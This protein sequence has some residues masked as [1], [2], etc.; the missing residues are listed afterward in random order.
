MR[1]PC[2]IRLHRNFA[3][4]LTYVKNFFCVL[5]CL[6][7]N[8]CG[9]ALKICA[10]SQK[11]AIMHNINKIAHQHLSNNTFFKKAVDISF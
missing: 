2:L 3:G 8:I 4:I 11:L 10:Q 6:A 9:V 7:V 1:L 5:C